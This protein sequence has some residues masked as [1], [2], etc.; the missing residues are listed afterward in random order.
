MM[1]DIIKAKEK[2]LIVVILIIIANFILLSI[3]YSQTNVNIRAYVPETEQ[4]KK[5]L[6]NQADNLQQPTT[7]ENKYQYF[8]EKFW[9]DQIDKEAK[10]AE[11]N[12]V[13]TV[14]DK[15]AS[16][17]LMWLILIAVAVIV[18]II[19]RI[20]DLYIIKHFRS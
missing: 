13:Q 2:L 11:Q 7:K 12:E 6:V 5:T 20:I 19:L 3:G 8:F 18:F 10:A 17:F 16:H 1:E 14:H 15:I 4:N 9:L